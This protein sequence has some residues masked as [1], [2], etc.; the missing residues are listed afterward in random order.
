MNAKGRRSQGLLLGTLMLAVGVTVGIC[1]WVL[2]ADPKAGM[3]DAIKTGGLAGAAIVALYGLWLN[4]RRRRVE[5]SR[6]FVEEERLRG[7]SHRISDERFARAIEMLGHEADQVR[8]GAMHVLVDLAR[9]HSRYAQ[10]VV[11]VLCAYLRRPFH[12]RSY[13][14]VAHDPDR[15]DFANPEPGELT[16]AQSAEDRERQVRLTAHRMLKELLPAAGTAQTYNLDLT[17]AALEYLDIEGREIGT[18][19]ARRATFYGITRAAE[20]RFQGMALFTGAVFR[21]RLDL[22]KAR[23]TGVSLQEVRLDEHANLAGSTFHAFADLRWQEPVDVRF[24]D[25]I[26]SADVRLRTHS[27]TTIELPNTAPYSTIAE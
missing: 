1:V 4:D 27:G 24:D 20:V 26:I 15:N 9:N 7:D 25:V 17:G 10:T 12:H 5:E 23:F 3:S 6:Q 11:D 18:L 8:T 19:L 21:G 14:S 2:K 22:R 16:D 13:T